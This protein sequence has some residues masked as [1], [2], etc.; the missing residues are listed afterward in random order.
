VRELPKLNQRIRKKR[1]Y[2]IQQVYIKTYK[3]GRVTGLLLVVL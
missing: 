1:I 2:P 3:E